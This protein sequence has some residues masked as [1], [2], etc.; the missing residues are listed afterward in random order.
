MNTVAFCN[1]LVQVVSEHWV[2]GRSTTNLE[3]LDRTMGLFR[4]SC[5][6]YVSH[7]PEND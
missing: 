2:I 3:I 5:L 1:S 6:E 7:C 4:G